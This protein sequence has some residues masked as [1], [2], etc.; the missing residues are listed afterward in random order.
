M[1]ILGP[2]HSEPWGKV[3]T[4]LVEYPNHDPAFYALWT[5]VSNFRTM[6]ALEVALPTLQI[7]LCANDQDL[8]HAVM[9]RL[10]PGVGTAQNFLITLEC[11]L[12]F[13]LAAFRNFDC[14]L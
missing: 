2:K 6:I 5:T 3:L 9:H 12:H 8:V 7:R 1:M 13:G 11:R 14:A 4:S 10:Q